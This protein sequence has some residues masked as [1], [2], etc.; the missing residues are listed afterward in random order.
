MFR[1]GEKGGDVRAE[2]AWRVYFPPHISDLLYADQSKCKWGFCGKQRKSATVGYLNWVV[3]I[4][5]NQEPITK[6]RKIGVRS[7]H[8]TKNNSVF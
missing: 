4:S 2:R 3:F 1:N 7:T 5:D 6:M 8:F